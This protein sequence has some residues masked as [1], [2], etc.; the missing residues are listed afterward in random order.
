MA[1]VH[2]FDI[3]S[4]YIHGKRVPIIFTFHQNTGRDL[5]MKQMFDM[6]KKLTVGQSDEIHGVNPIDWEDSSWK[7]Y[8]WSVMKKSSV[9]RTRRF[10]YFQILWYALER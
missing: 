7:Q 3:G 1:K 8:L 6:S 2:V 9:S 10:T 5:T 4:I